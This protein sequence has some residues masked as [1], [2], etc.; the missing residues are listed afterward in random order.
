MEL[1]AVGDLVVAEPEALRAIADPF[2]LALLDRLR[3]GGPATT[4][5]LGAG[6]PLSSHLQELERLGFVTREGIRWSAVGKGIYFEI[7][8]EPEGQAAARELARVILLN[9]DERPRR[10]A[11]TD[12]PRLPLEWARAAGM[13]NARVRLTV[14]ELR[15]VQEELEH[16]LAPFTSRE[17]QDAPDEA[18]TVRVLAYFMPESADATT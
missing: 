16:V 17:P 14:D 2:R 4:A 10:W 12:E 9:E 5:E 3:R 11:E 18:A 8:A 7:P 6:E 13:F 15:E 1:N